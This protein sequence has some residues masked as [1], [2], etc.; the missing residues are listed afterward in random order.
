MVNTKPHIQ[1][2]SSV[3]L[4][5]NIAVP[6]ISY[7]RQLYLACTTHREIKESCAGLGYAY[8]YIAKQDLMKPNIIVMDT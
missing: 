7:I 6:G 1:W 5:L 4:L 8:M 2:Q 3:E